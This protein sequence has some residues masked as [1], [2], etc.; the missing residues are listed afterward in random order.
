MKV[1]SQLLVFCQ[2]KSVHVVKIIC[3]VPEAKFTAIQK[4][5]IEKWTFAPG[6]PSYLIH[7]QHIDATG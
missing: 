7:E 2:L 1:K 3:S 6:K 4:K 5:D